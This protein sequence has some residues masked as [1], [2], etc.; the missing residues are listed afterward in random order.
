MITLSTLRPWSDIERFI[1]NWEFL[2]DD[3]AAIY[4]EHGTRL[5]KI[6]LIETLESKSLTLQSLEFPTSISIKRENIW[7]EQIFSCYRNKTEL[8]SR[9]KVDNPTNPKNWLYLNSS[10]NIIFKIIFGANTIIQKTIQD[11]KG[12]NS[13]QVRNIKSKDNIKNWDE[14]KTFM[15]L[16]PKDDVERMH[17]LTFVTFLLSILMEESY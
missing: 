2:Q 8:F 10:E 14:S 4:E 12:A 15:L 3:T 16:I 1:I 13:G 6:E 11:Q 5:C 7:K 9:I 17:L